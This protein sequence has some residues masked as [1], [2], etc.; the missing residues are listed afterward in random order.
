MRCTGATAILFFQCIFRENCTEQK[1]VSAYIVYLNRTNN[2]IFEN[3]HTDTDES[4]RSVKM[5]P[6]YQVFE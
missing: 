5:Q 6:N 3:K 2:F 1:E 4:T